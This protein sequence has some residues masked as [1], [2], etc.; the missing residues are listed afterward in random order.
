VIDN[1]KILTDS[2]RDDFDHTIEIN[3]QNEELAAK[4]EMGVKEYSDMVES[5]GHLQQEMY[6]KIVS[7]K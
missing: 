6:R 1:Y 5:F 2:I 7:L 3:R 4:I